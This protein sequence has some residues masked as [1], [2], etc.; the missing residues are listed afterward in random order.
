M[1]MTATTPVPMWG[2]G[3]SLGRGALHLWTSGLDR[4][5]AE[6]EAL[7]STLSSDERERAGRFHFE[8]DRR[9]FTVGRGFLRTLLAQYLGRSAAALEFRYGPHGKPELAGRGAV[10]GLRFN[11]SHSGGRALCALAS[12]VAVGA[13]LE[14]TRS[15]DNL[16]GLAATVFSA[17]E[18]ATLHAL[19]APERQAAFYRCWTRK[20]AFI[21]ALGDG[22]SCPLD[23]F[24]VT[25]A[26]GEP[27]RLLRIAGDPDG[28]E[29]WSLHSF[30][31]G[32]WVGAVA[33]AGPIDSL[34]GG[35][36]PWAG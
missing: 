5:P 33:V 16:E 18:L 8:R 24:D 29:R 36:W 35:E 32:E 28:P 11:L 21:K 15:L 3:S 31:D 9:R 20:E 26:P 17:G 25:L 30:E 34:V 27:A 12:D 14:L 2:P 1:A 23:R 6:V 13:D 7:A 4:S 10:S 22:L 19:P